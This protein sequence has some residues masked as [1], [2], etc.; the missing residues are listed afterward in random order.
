MVMAR[1]LSD[2]N[3]LQGFKDFVISGPLTNDENKKI[4]KYFNKKCD[5]LSDDYSDELKSEEKLITKFKKDKKYTKY[6]TDITELMY[7]KGKTRRMNYTT[8][9]DE[10]KQ[11]NQE[12]TLKNIY[13]TT[14]YGQIT[15]TIFDGKI[16]L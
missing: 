11:K 5:D 7:P 14:N 6:T 2:P 8:V 10:S 1:V 9:K 3:K 4:R 16:T 13:G 15:L 12:Q